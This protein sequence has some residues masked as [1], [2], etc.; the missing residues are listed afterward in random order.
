MIYLYSILIIALSS[1]LWRIRGGLW[2]EYIP[3]NKIWYVVAFGLY[4]CFYF[5]FSF[6][7]WIVGFLAAYASYQSFG[8]GLYIG[9]L[10]SGGKLN[11][12]L[13]QYRECELIDDLLYSLHVT[14]KGNKYYLY[15]YPRLFGFIG[16]SLT[17]LIIT[18]LWGLYLGNILVMVS[19]LAMGICYWLG[20]LL[21]K[22]IPEQKAGWGYGEYIFGS[23]LGFVLSWVMLW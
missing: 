11:P 12:N 18:F 5:S 14:L 3:A 23:F 21:N 16:T 20:H 9:R 2:K 10:I 19:G 4:G 6:E 7:N 22:L 17:G 1:I 13:V 8:W 15:Q